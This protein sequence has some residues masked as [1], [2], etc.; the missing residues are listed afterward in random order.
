ME[1]FRG[2]F[3]AG[4]VLVG[5]RPPV[6]LGSG[7]ERV[8]SKVWPI[9]HACGG[10]PRLVLSTFF[11]LGLSPQGE[12]HQRDGAPEWGRPYDKAPG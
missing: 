5:G 11:G 10:T 8:N 3:P 6:L 12:R 9:A 7:N 1:F 2:G 4:F